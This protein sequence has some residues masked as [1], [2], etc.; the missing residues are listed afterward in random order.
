M[1]VEHPGLEAAGDV[2]DQPGPD[3]G[4][5]G[6][7]Q[8]RAERAR[9]LVLGIRRRGQ[10]VRGVAADHERGAAH[11]RRAR[12]RPTTARARSS[13]RRRSPTAP[14]RR[15]GS[16][17]RSRPGP[18][19]TPAGTRAASANTQ[20]SDGDQSSGRVREVSL[21]PAVRR[22]G[23]SQTASTPRG[24]GC[25]LRAV[26]ELLGGAVPDRHGV[27]EGGEVVGGDRR[28]HLVG[29]DRLDA[30]PERGEP[31][32]VA[33]DAAAEI[34]DARSCPHRGSAPHAEPRPRAGSPARGR[35]G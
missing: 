13:S 20:S 8:E 4:A 21:C 2:A 17:S 12:A 5:V 30:Q 32:R 22:A 11:A 3:H 31:Q 27:A 6:L 7:V 35:P 19:L 15:R 26:D 1:L 29:V 24:S 28:G 33:A 9:R 16:A 34:G 10:L 14:R 23:S 25:R 18:S